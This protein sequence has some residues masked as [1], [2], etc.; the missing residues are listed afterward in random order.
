[1]TSGNICDYILLALK[2]NSSKTRLNIILNMLQT[3]YEEKQFSLKVEG[4]YCSQTLCVRIIDLSICYFH[5][6]KDYL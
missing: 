5:L 3:I 4:M 1:M 6:I 2:Y